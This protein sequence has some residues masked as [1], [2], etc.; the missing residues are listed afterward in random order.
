MGLGTRIHASTLT[1]EKNL[2]NDILVDKQY[3]SWINRTKRST[4]AIGWVRSGVLWRFGYA[5]TASAVFVHGLGGCVCLIAVY[6]CICT[7]GRSFA[8]IVGY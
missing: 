2:G 4:G 5:P 8:Y 3:G 6:T 7:Y 1:R